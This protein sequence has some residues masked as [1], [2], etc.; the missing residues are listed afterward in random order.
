[1]AGPTSFS[2]AWL[3]QACGSVLKAQARQDKE[4]QHG[5]LAG[6]LLGFAAALDHCQAC[7]PAPDDYQPYLQ[8]LLCGQHHFHMSV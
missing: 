5:L 2:A 4:Q 6:A 3:L 1:M 8:P 7:S